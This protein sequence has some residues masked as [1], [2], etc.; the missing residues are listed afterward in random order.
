MPVPSRIGPGDHPDARGQ[1][2]SHGLQ[3]MGTER[4]RTL[5]HVRR[6]RLAVVFIDGQGRDEKDAALDHH[7]NQLGVLVEVAG[8][9]SIEHG[10][11]LDEDPE[12]IPMMVERGI[13]FVPT[14]T[15]YEYHRE[16]TAPHVR[17]RRSEERR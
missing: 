2:V 3:M 17:E 14:L 4:P 16:S 15:V 5:A 6:R 7:R 8:V 11:Y 13:F 1:G 10:C 9:D 12:L